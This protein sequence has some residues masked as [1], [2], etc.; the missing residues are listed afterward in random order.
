MSSES[1]PAKRQPS[2]QRQIVRWTGQSLVLFGVWLAFSGYLYPEFLVLG[3]V[4]AV[5]GTATAGWLF[6]GTGD[7]RLEHPDRSYARDVRTALR[8]ILYVPWL[9]WVAILSN[10]HVAYVVLHP[11]LP[12]DPTLVEFDTSLGSEQSQVLLAQSITLTPGTVT[13]DVSNGKLLVHCLSAKSRQGLVEGDIQ[14]KVANVFEESA[15]DRVALTDI[16]AFEQV[17]L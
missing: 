17:P 7:P 1:S 15:P 4:S 16:T 2:K 5:A 10:L 12:V 3:A 13:I 11:K 6:H 8:F 9:T 14:R